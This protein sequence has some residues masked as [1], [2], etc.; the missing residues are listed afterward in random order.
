MEALVK[1]C[2]RA[3]KKAIGDQELAPFELYTYFVKVANLINERP[4]GQVPND[5]DDGSY[6]CPNDILLGRSSS[7]V[8]QGPFRET[9]NPRHQV[10]FIQRIVDSFWK[11]WMRDVF[12]VLVPRKKWN[13]DKRDIKVDDVVI[14]KDTNAVRGNSTVGKVIKVYPGQDGKI[15]NTKVIR[16]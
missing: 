12:P 8:P 15:V 11:C 6:I 5:P 2:K 7:H 10:E 1:S 13:T 9:R 16:W 14:V 3:L 4:I